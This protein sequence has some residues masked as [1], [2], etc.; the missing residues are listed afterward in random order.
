MVHVHEGF[1]WV[2]STFMKEVSLM[3]TLLNYIR[4]CIHNKTVLLAS[5]FCC[6]NGITL[7]TFCIEYKIVLDKVILCNDNKL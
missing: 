3:A 6:T 4:L 1:H 2:A 7:Q 5:T